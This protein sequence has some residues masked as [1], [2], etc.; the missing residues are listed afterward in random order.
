LWKS[1]ISTPG[2]KALSGHR[3][4]ATF[5]LTEKTLFLAAAEAQHSALR[6]IVPS[7]RRGRATFPLSEKSLFQAAEEEQ[8]F[9]SPKNTLFLPVAEERLFR[10]PKNCF[11]WPARKNDITAPRK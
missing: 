10:S 11:I 5:P 1:D 8:L 7:I 9:R 3:R 4:R 2:K 6:K